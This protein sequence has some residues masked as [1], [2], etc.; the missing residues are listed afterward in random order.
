VNKIDALCPFCIAN[1]KAAEKFKGEFQ[2]YT[3]IEGISP[4]PNEPNTADI[5]KDAI[6]EVIERTPG[7]C[8]CQQEV[9]LNHCGDL[10]AF[11]GYVIW[12]EIKDKLYEFVDLEADCGEIN[13]S[14][15][16]LPV[17]L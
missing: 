7:Y 3:S 14:I 16:D 5:L 2:S 13:I 12:D 17:C 8:G 15:N 1:G 6:E 9:W 10:C 11:I 4:V